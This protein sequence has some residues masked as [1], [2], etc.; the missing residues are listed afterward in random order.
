M[1]PGVEIILSAVLDKMFGNVMTLVE[2]LF[3]NWT[4]CIKESHNDNYTKPLALVSTKT[5]LY[6]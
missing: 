4:F 2:F 1:Q 3:L 6:V 5:W